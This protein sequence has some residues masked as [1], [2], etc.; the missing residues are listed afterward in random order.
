LFDVTI[1]ILHSLCCEAHVLSGERA[2]G[3]DKHQQGAPLV[4]LETPP[5]GRAQALL[6]ELEVSQVLQHLTRVLEP[7]LQARSERTEGRH[8]AIRRTHDPQGRVEE[9]APLGRALG[10]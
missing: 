4:G 1:L 3:V 6:R 5:L 10:Q 9:L 2:G 8:A 7:G